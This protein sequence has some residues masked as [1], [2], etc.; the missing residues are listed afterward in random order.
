MPILWR[1]LLSHYL[2]IFL[3]SISAFTLLL[4]ISR[5]HETASFA[6]LGAPLKTLFF[7]VLYQFPYILPIAIPI[8]CLIASLLMMQKLSRGHEVVAFFSVGLS[9]KKLFAPILTFSIF[10]SLLNFYIAS[11]IATDARLSSKKMI[12]DISSLNPLTLLNN[13]QF[14][15]RKDCLIKTG[16]SKGGSKCKNVLIA[17]RRQGDTRTLLFF[18]KEINL[19]EQELL[20]KNVALISSIPSKEGRFD[21]LIIENQ[22]DIKTPA[23]EFTHL[24]RKN[25]WRLC[26]DHLKMPLLLC[27]I[28]QEKTF[29]SSK[30]QNQNL[31]KCY[32]EISRRLQLG[33]TPFAF[34]FLGLSF[35]LEISRRRLKKGIIIVSSLAALSFACFFLGKGMESNFKLSA[36]FYFIPIVLILIA[37]SI[38]IRRIIKGK[39]S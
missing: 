17:L 39:E 34:T 1:Y 4:I 16:A 11:E 30:S 3:L 15:K 32:S 12:Q 19:Q 18:A 37:S 6:S 29:N 25:P 28:K 13:A 10:L 22:A 8:S 20:G 21:H 38:T 14:L 36:T 33:I 27:K 23:I 31:N 7:F 5:L 24:L 2:K 26:P 9:L 35:G